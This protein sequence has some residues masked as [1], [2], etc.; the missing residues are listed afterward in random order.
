M[1]LETNT[2]ELREVLELAENISGGSGGGSGGTSV[3]T[4]TVEYCNNNAN[5]NHNHSIAYLSYD[6]GEA[7]IKVLHGLQRGTTYTIEN[8][9]CNSV[10]IVAYFPYSANVY[11]VENAEYVSYFGPISSYSAIFKIT[12]SNGGKAIINIEDD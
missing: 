4:C 6:N 10:I 1:S 3:E 9:S 12:A 5:S 7:E 11:N 2:S 8:V